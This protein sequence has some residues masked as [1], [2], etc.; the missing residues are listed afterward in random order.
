MQKKGSYVIFLML[1]SMVGGRSYGQ[2]YD[3]IIN[4][5]GINGNYSFSLTE[6]PERLVSVNPDLGGTVW[7]WEQSDK[8]ITDF[9]DIAG[10]V[11]SI[12][13]FSTA[14]SVTRYYR[15]KAILYC[16][17]WHLEIN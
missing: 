11:N 8:P 2:G 14:L 10:E 1:L 6:I 12:L 16:P 5:N 7:Q 15:R 3:D 17:C 9:A 13:S 4:V